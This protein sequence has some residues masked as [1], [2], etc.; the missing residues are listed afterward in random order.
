MTVFVKQMDG[1]G[2]DWYPKS[3]QVDKCWKLQEVAIVTMVWTCLEYEGMSNRKGLVG[4]HF[5][6]WG[7]IGRRP[8]SNHLTSALIWIG[9]SALGPSDMHSAPVT[10]ICCIFFLS[11]L[12][13]LV[14]LRHL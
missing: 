10:G 4:I 8:S 1:I 3:S 14:F 5:G 7:K 6:S 12:F 13:C 9:G 11:D 2:W